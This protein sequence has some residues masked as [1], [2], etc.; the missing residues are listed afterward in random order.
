V[1]AWGFNA[2]GQVS[3]LGDGISGEGSNVL[4]PTKLSLMPPD[5]ASGVWAGPWCTFVSTKM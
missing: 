3:P 1:Y 5:Q 4:V 2:F